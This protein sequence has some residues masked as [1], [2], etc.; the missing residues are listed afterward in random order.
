[1]MDVAGDVHFEKT[2]DVSR[3]FCERLGSVGSSVWRQLGKK[4]V[5]VRQRDG[6]LQKM[7]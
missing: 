5:H 1:M 4:V 3:D 7:I 6:L 2:A